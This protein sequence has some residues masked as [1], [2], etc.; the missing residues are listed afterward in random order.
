MHRTLDLSVPTGATD[1]LLADLARLEDVVGLSVN[2]GAS[3]K[4]PGDV[5]VVHVLNRGADG[6]LRLAGQVGPEVS[7]VTAETASVIDP[8]HDSRVEND[9]DEAIWEE[10]ETGLRHQGRVSPNFLA[11]M[12]LGGVLGAVGMVSEGVPQAIAFV[13]A[14][15]IA[16]A[17][18]PIAKL[19]LGA[20]LRRG[21]VA[22]RGIQSVL[23][24]YAVFILAAG[25]TFLLLRAAGSA[26]VREFT[27]N[28]EL[29]RL[30]SP[31]GKDLLFS[32]VGALS[33][34]VIMASYR[35]SVIAGALVALVLIPAAASVGMS[36]SLGRLDLAW[37][38]L[39]RFGLDVLLVVG[40]GWA[41]FAVKQLTVHRR[42]PLV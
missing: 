20:A 11:L 7:V 31:G 19:A 41:V 42:P 10:V 13:A 22:R 34:A 14:S 8:R 5:I 12:A 28:T 32:V 35:R 23:A 40:L 37:Q 25:L 18:E 9:V 38:S 39:E 36:L 4:P 30:A 15:I 24:G 17:F 2:R 27:E 6:V 3:V 16:P 1:G 33:G 29:A 21:N 26:T